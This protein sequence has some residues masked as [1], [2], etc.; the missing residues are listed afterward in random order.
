[1]NGLFFARGATAI[2]GPMPMAERPRIWTR[3]ARFASSNDRNWR[4]LPVEGTA[5]WQRMMAADR[6]ARRV[7]LLLILTAALVGVA[8]A[9]L[10][11]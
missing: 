10:K 5:R 3:P 2:V 1:M 6:R 11:G 4:T 8:V 7:K 9:L